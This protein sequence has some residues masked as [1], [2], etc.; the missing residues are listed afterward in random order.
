MF[1]GWLHSVF[2]TGVLCFG[3]DGTL[4]WGRHNC[5]GSW[6]DGE[7][8]RRLQEIL[9]DPWRTGAGMKIASDSAFPV[10]GRCA[11]RIITPLK[12]GDLE[13]HPHDCRLGMKAMSDSIT[14][15]RQAAEW[16]MGAVGKVY[17]QLLLPLPY[18]PAVRAMRL[19]SIF[20]LYNFR[21]RRTGIS[22]IKN[23]FGA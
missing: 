8:S 16:G 11:G 21:V 12:E 10:S 3:I 2:V 18:N 20:K 5:P 23:V 1:N 15:L 19:N 22:Q 7:M 4:I 17:R 6:N 13:R 9:S 14:S